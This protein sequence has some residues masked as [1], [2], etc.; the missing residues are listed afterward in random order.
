MIKITQRE[1][2]TQLKYNAAYAHEFIFILFFITALTL[3]FY[4]WMGNLEQHQRHVKHNTHAFPRPTPRRLA[5]R[6]D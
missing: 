3:P 6:G 5:E 1:H 2:Q 4:K